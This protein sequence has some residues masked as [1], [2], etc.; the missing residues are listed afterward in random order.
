MMLLLKTDSFTTDIVGL[1]T[2]QKYMWYM[3]R[4]FEDGAMQPVRQA[5]NA[6]EPLNSGIKRTGVRE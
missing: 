6:A 5:A 1:K 3:F 4:S 2:R